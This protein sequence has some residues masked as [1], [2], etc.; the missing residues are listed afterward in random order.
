MSV[1]GVS[2]RA[3]STPS[4][5]LPPRCPASRAGGTAAPAISACPPG[6]ERS[7][8]VVTRARLLAIA[9]AM[10][11]VLAAATCSQ[12]CSHRSCGEACEVEQKLIGRLGGDPYEFSAAPGASRRFGVTVTSAPAR[13]AAAVTCDPFH[14]SSCTVL[15]SQSRRW[16]NII[17][18]VAV[19]SSSRHL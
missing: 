7:P 6:S 16:P 2:S 17:N 13:T 1:L 8:I 12:I 4:P 9:P 18:A 14:G 10:S 19:E 3:S 5:S 15:A 11:A